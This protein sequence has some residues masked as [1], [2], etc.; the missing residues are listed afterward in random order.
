MKALHLRPL[1]KLS[2]ALA[3]TLASLGA[4][5]AESQTVNQPAHHNVLNKEPSS[6]SASAITVTPS[7]SYMSYRDNILFMPG[8][9]LDDSLV[10]TLLRAGGESVYRT[11][12]HH[13]VMMTLHQVYPLLGSRNFS[14]YTSLAIPVLINLW[15]LGNI[16]PKAWSISRQQIE[17]VQNT[18]GT[19]RQGRMP[20]YAGKPLDQAVFIDLL[21]NTQEATFN[22][23]KYWQIEITPLKPV[24][25]EQLSTSWHKAL[26]HLV[27][28]ALTNNIDVIHLDIP[29]GGKPARLSLHSKDGNWKATEFAAVSHQ[30]ADQ[31]AD[32]Q[33][34]QQTARQTDL[35]H[36]LEHSYNRS[37][38]EDGLTT[39]LET[40]GLNCIR[41]HIQALPHKGEVFCQPLTGITQALAYGPP[42]QSFQFNDP[43]GEQPAY[44]H[45]LNNTSIHPGYPGSLVVSD[46]PI[47]STSNHERL[48]GQHRMSTSTAQA[49]QLAIDRMLAYVA[50]SVISTA[51]DIPYTFWKRYG[52]TRLE[53]IVT[54]DGMS[55]SR[56]QD[57]TGK[58]WIMKEITIGLGADDTSKSYDQMTEL[59][60]LSNLKSP[61]I[62][63]LHDA[64]LEHAGTRAAKL[65][66][67]TSDDGVNLMTAADKPGFKL[68]SMDDL[69]NV[70]RGALHGLKDMHD[71]GYAHLDVKPGNMVI[72]N[73]GE[74]RLID[75]DASGIM[76]R[77]GKV[78]F[79]N[80]TEI[81]QSPE[82]NKSHW[83]S[84][85]TDIWSLGIAAL[86]IRELH[87]LEGT[88]CNDSNLTIWNAISILSGIDVLIPEL[89]GELVTDGLDCG[90]YSDSPQ[91][92]DFFRQ[93]LAVSPKKR[94]SAAT[95][96]KHPFLKTTTR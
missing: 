35:L 86:H 71:A 77:N 74:T 85:K 34:G 37:V 68:K 54:K 23:G 5:A 70:L 64:W 11:L 90:I 69:K 16:L 58:T 8:V 36:W 76:N 22:R 21:I 19:L 63:K 80:L 29:K 14:Y 9:H 95:L 72:N 52:L 12:I 15:A 84:E 40:Q 83:I 43:D 61:H 13:L 62:T 53:K 18:T 66:M 78:Y 24:D 39:V 67:L 50:N 10:M 82:Q 30:Q 57:S 73:K 25:T 17:R 87:G 41:N 48:S 7:G 59:A 32:Q 56:V 45:I 20:L 88:S 89:R 3:I 60:V 1:L 49:G 4:T 38:P 6:D 31:Q 28:D 2:A 55:V 92:L 51:L 75:F 96:L 46:N 91:F 44:V 81:Y 65:V 33:A 42:G 47:L 94:S 26:G 27:N 93:M 79:R